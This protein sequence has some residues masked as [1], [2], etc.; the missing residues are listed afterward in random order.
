MSGE[1]ENT[2][3]IRYADPDED[4]LQEEVDTALTQ[5]MEERFKT[6]CDVVVAN[7]A[8]AG[9]DVVNYPIKKV[10]AYGDEQQS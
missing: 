4:I 7:F 2:R 10:I 1:I 9:I 3:T 8:M 5:T 6:Y